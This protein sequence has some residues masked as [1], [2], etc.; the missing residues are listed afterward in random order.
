MANVPRPIKTINHM[1]IKTAYYLLFYKLYCF[2][3]AAWEDS[4]SDWKSLIAINTLEIL[5]ITGLCV[6]LEVIFKVSVDLS[7]NPYAF[8]IPIAVIIVVSNYFI[9]LQKNKWKSYAE[10]FKNYSKAKKQLA[11]WTV[12]VFVLAILANVIL[13]FYAMSQI[14]WAKYR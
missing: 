4:W 10:K 9:F 13:A 14:D 2:F 8:V 12:F 6:W 1:N 7:A 11:S 5:L 3:K